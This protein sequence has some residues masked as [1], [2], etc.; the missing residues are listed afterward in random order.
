LR[1][2]NVYEKFS[3]IEKALLSLESVDEEKI[4][5][6][7]D[8]LEKEEKRL[9]EKRKKLH[10]AIDSAREEILARLSQAK[11]KA[12][13]DVYAKAVER[14][15]NPIFGTPDDLMSRKESDLEIKEELSGLNF[16]ELEEYYQTLRDEEALVSFKRRMV[17]GKIDILKNHLLLRLSATETV[18]NEEFAKKLAR[19]LT[20]KGF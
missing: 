18:S 7:I 10:R 3:E 8:I 15:L 20:E 9:S 12:S 17:Q 6:Y 4:R 14:L 5:E 13:E 2:I 16:D 11:K 19:L 1:V